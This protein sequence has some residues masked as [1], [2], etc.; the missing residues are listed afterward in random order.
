MN[1]RGVMPGGEADEDAPGQE[2]HVPHVEVPEKGLPVHGSG[3]DQAANRQSL[4]SHVDGAVQRQHGAAPTNM[5]QQRA[6][7]PPA[8]GLHEPRPQQSAENLQKAGDPESGDQLWP[9]FNS[10]SNFAPGIAAARARP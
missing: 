3:P 8:L 5:K 9:V 10:S 6:R 4:T 2:G 7:E 1:S